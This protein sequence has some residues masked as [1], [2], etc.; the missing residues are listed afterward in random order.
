MNA[1]ECDNGIISLLYYSEVIVVT[2]VL[3]TTIRILFSN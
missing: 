1:V 2:N 3:N